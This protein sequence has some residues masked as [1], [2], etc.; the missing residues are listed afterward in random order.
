[1]IF[2]TTVPTLTS[3]TI[4]KKEKKVYFL[5]TFRKSNLT[6]WTTNEMF[7]GQRFAILAMFLLRDCVIYC[8]KRLHDF[9]VKRLRDF[10]CEEVFF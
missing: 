9:C 7:S 8:M 4:I 1:M 10:L 2:L 3:V 5:R 6:H